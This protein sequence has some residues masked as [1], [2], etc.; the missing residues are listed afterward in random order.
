MQNDDGRKPAHAVPNWQA[1]ASTGKLAGHLGAAWWRVRS[2][3]EREEDK[4]HPQAGG[5]SATQARL[6]II[7]QRDHDRKPRHEIW[8]DGYTSKGVKVRH[9]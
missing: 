2:S 4:D 1:L 7:G 3:K 9:K 6:G 8:D 5:P